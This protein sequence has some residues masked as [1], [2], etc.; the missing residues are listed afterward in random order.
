MARIHV[1]VLRGGPSREYDVS[2]ASGA[3]VLKHLADDRYGTKDIFID[4]NG[5]WHVRGM[6]T[7][8]GRALRDV[9]V[10]FNAL[11]GEY[12]EDGTVQRILESHSVP[13]TGSGVF[14]S[15]LAMDKGRTR[16]HV[17]SIPHVKMPGSIVVQK[18]KIGDGFALTANNIF[19]KFGP[20]YI[21]KPLRGG[22]SV[23]LRVVHSVAE[24]PPALFDALEETDAVIVEQYIR[25]REATVGVVEQLRDDPLYRLPP[26]EIVLPKSCTAFDY[27]AKYSGTTEEV[28]PA[29]FTHEQKEQLQDAA[30]HIHQSL[31]LRHY[32][33][34]DFIVTPHGIYFLE[35]NTLP[36]LTP[37]SLLP[38]SL[39]A[40]GVRFPE[41]LDHVITIARNP[42]KRI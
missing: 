3:A 12:G 4:R 19:A 31:G 1:G 11:H 20:P 26:I 6:P 42:Q 24:L 16:S 25:G 38:K 23:G 35:V 28:C 5:R 40:V 15:A 39:D 27:T 32:S 9:D 2:L 14:S 22:S 18:E 7:D 10:V 17:G 33:R 30:R 21:V 8:P 41:F 36:G 34:S 37:S 13:Y 29:N